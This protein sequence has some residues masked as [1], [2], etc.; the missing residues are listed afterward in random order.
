MNVKRLVGAGDRIALTTLPFLAIGLVAQFLRPSWFTVGG[1]SSAL[2]TVSRVAIVPGIVL[3]AWSVVLI[4]IKVPRR[5]LITTGPFALVKH[6]LYTSV[7]L[8]VLPWAGF[9]MNSWLGVVIGAALYGAS[10]RNSPQEERELSATFGSAWDEY[11]ARVKLPW[12]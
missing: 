9:L 1:P 10:R 7:S 12:L 11:S 4:L 8:L 6:P 5:E 3:W 2:R